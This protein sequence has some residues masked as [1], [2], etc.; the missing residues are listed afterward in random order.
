[1]NIKRII[2]VVMAVVIIASLAMITTSAADTADENSIVVHCKSEDGVPN[3]YYWNSLPENQEVDYPGVAMT[4]D[5][6]QGENWY[7][8]TFKN[9]TKVNMLFIVNGEQSAEL[10]RSA[11]GEYWYK[12]SK[13]YK[14]N[15]ELV[16]QYDR[17]DLREDSIYFVVTTRFYDG[18]TSNNV[19]CWDDASYNN[20]DS[21]PAWRGD[22]KGL[23]EKLD[24]IKALGFSAIWITPVVTN[25]SGYD[26]HGYHAFD[27]STVDAR[28]ESSDT[29]FQD[30][31]DACHEKDMKIIQ[32]V[33]WNHT[34]NFG[35]ATFCELFTKEY[36]TIQDLADIEKSMVPTDLLLD[37]WGLSSAEEY[38]AQLPGL[39]HDQRLNIMK[40]L[41]IPSSES[42][43]PYNPQ[44]A[45]RGTQAAI[46]NP[47]MV[48]ADGSKYNSYNYYHNG[49]WSSVN[50][51]DFACKYVQIAGDCVDL[52]TENP[53]V[54]EKLVDIYSD[55]I[56]MGVDAFRV[57][58]VRHMSRLTLNMMYLP[59]L[60]SAADNFYMFGETCTRYGGIWYR[61]HA[62]ES[63][64]FYTW[65]ESDPT[66]AENW[67]WG[68]DSAS[69]RNNMVL[70]LQHWAKN[71]NNFSEQPQSKNAFLDGNAYHTPDWSQFSGLGGIDFTMHYN[72]N[73]ASSAFNLAL[74]EDP[75]F[76]DSTWNVVY[77]DSHDYSPGPNDSI[78]FN[79]G[80]QQWAEN[81]NLM[82]TFRGIPCIYYGSEIEFQKGVKIDGGGPEGSR[83]ALAETGRAYY[84]DHIE[85]EITATDFGEYKASGVVADTLNNPLAKHI[86][87]L[88]L[89]RRT[90]PAL[91][92][93]QYSTNGCSGSVAF[94]RRYT[95]GDIDSYVLV[96]VSGASTFTGIENGT[97]YEAITG[98]KVV[99]TDNTLKSDSIGKG[100]VRIYVLD[101]PSNT[102]KGQIGETG[103]YL[104]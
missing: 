26:Y 69:V 32:D 98:E 20:P 67:S 49:Y 74:Q 82:F 93:G 2:A 50:W 33:V 99:V 23:I 60:T 39:Q 43:P 68:T 96:T 102:V 19:H 78:R 7:T 70:T 79:G 55:Y 97:Y 31:I 52:N 62:S 65:K 72:F 91:Q 10:T 11:S 76:N 104:K 73:N 85:G 77:V 37:T 90:I 21:D 75:Y 88:N 101:T 103:T 14:S 95:E 84:G 51:D 92:K 17:T 3:I 80:T 16:D 36:D 89:I 25:A 100:N 57:D 12:N 15:P 47:Y 54:A 38:W 18:D 40:D 35:E 64:Q 53:Y 27:F 41:T 9:T 48:Q 94:K 4:K 59:G 42:N 83:T 29:D 44:A 58:T 66:Y 24:Y 1:M 22:F 71:D 6:S 13:W 56:D 61:E 81:L 87:R 63:T 45:D 28:Y 46:D 86:Q 5:A 8:Y 34:G 30:L